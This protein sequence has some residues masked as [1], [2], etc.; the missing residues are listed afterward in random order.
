MQSVV[1][2][3]QFTDCINKYGYLCWIYVWCNSVTEVK[4]MSVAVAE[5]RENVCSLFLNF[6]ITQSE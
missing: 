1:L 5:R 4:D 2:P 6:R 3:A